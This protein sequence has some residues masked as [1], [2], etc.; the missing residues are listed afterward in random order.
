[1]AIT[2]RPG[3]EPWNDVWSLEDGGDNLGIAV[4]PPPMGSGQPPG[5]PPVGKPTPPLL[6]APTPRVDPAGNPQG[7]TQRGP[8]NLPTTPGSLVG[9][10]PPSTAAPSRPSEPTPVSGSTPAPVTQ[11]PPPFQPMPTGMSPGDSTVS[12]VVRRGLV[13]GGPNQQGAAL[14]G[15]AGG[16]LGGGLGV[17]G[18]MGAGSEDISDLIAQIYL[19]ANRR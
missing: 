19:M 11:P 14:L 8:I 17:P 10:A 5:T 15:K 3:S 13:P 9:G 12:T 18:I 2:R 16:L 6:S 7:P 4:S 1:M